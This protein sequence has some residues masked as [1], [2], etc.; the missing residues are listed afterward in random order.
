LTGIGRGLIAARMI[1]IAT[2]L[3]ARRRRIIAA[4]ADVRV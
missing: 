1:N 4:W 3:T 2:I